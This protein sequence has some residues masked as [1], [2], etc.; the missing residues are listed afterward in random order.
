MGRKR[1]I[2]PIDNKKTEQKS[3][4]DL[5]K[6]RIIE[7]E[8]LLGIPELRKFCRHYVGELDDSIINFEKKGETISKIYHQT[9]GSK[10]VIIGE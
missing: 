8:S 2:Q 7:V 6:Y 1:K 3:K 10:V 4:V 5:S 9:S